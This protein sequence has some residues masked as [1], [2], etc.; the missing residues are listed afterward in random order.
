MTIKEEYRHPK[1]DAVLGYKI[2]DPEIRIGRLGPGRVAPVE[3]L[4][5]GNGGTVYAEVS[6]NYSRVLRILASDEKGQND[7]VE[8]LSP[9]YGKPK[10][11][12]YTGRE[13]NSP[14]NSADLSY[15]KTYTDRLP[16]SIWAPFRRRSVKV[17]G[18]K[19]RLVSMQKM[20][21]AQRT[22]VVNLVV[23]E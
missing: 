16:F 10:S 21:P 3:G 20:K 8:C 5:L 1:T 13:I 6:T 18:A 17:E 7:K 19:V 12:T 4:T 2:P 23:E 14:K 11:V 22:I 15:V 9:G